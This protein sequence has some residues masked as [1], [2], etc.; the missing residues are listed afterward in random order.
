[1][2]SHNCKRHLKHIILWGLLNHFPLAKQ[3]VYDR[4]A[5]PIHVYR[6]SH[7]KIADADPL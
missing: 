4:A 5:D 3:M 1:M 2:V 7:F 6:G